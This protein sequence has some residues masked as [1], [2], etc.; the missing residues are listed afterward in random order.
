MAWIMCIAASPFWKVEE[1]VRGE[2]DR[3]GRV[4]RNGEEVR[5]RGWQEKGIPVFQLYFLD[6]V[7]LNHLQ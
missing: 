1:M 5:E 7:N 4:G 2:G 3:E 6:I